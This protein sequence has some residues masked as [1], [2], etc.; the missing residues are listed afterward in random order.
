MQHVKDRISERHLEEILHRYGIEKDQVKFLNS[1]ANLIYEFERDGEFFILRVGHTS[2]RDGLQTMGEIDWL[3]HLA[4]GGAGVAYPLPSASGQFVEEVADGEGGQY[5]AVSFIKARGKAV[6]D[7]VWNE[8]FFKAYGRHMGK[9]HALS[10]TYQLPN[11][12]WKRPVWDL[13]GM[14]PIETFLPEPSQAHLVKN[15]F[16]IKDHLMSLSKHADAYGLTHQD[17]HKGNLFVDEDYTI[18]MYDFDDC[19][20]GFFIHDLAM[21]LFY[22]ALRED[23]R[24]TFAQEFL[25]PFLKGYAQENKLDPVWLKELPHFMKLREIYLYAIAVY[26]S[27]TQPDVEWTGNYINMLRQSVDENL[28]YIDLDFSQYA[29]LLL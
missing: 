22:A 15:F 14:Y 9:I 7:V 12:A 29:D 13:P 25:P 6:D 4:K 28:A 21:V 5:V 20:Y 8:R 18:T 19:C 1:L 10:Q 26:I 3:Q 23:D 27:K 17:P 11:E 2:R 16:K 24:L